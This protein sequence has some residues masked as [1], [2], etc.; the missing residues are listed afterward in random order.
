MDSSYDPIFSKLGITASINTTVSS[1]LAFKRVVDEPGKRLV[2]LVAG[3]KA[4]VFE[5]SVDSKSRIAD[6]RIK[7]FESEKFTIAAIFRDG[8]FLKASPKERIQQGDTIIIVS[9]VEEVRNVDKLF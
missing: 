3:E 4:E 9:P 8:E 7:E 6:K 1:I 2:N 5:R